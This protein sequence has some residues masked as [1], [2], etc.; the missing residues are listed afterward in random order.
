[1]IVSG[2]MLSELCELVNLAEAFCNCNGWKAGC[3]NNSSGAKTQR[4]AISREPPFLRR[5]HHFKER[6]QRVDEVFK[7]FKLGCLDIDLQ[8]LKDR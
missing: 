4:A 6:S 8:Q 3:D 2:V 5:T 7:L 1:M